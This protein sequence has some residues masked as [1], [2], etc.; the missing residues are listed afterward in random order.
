MQADTQQFVS[1]GARAEFDIYTGAGSKVPLTN[2]PG[3][4]CTSGGSGGAA[5]TLNSNDRNVYLGRGSKM[6][7]AISASH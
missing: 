7:L 3:V 5:A 2:L 4:T 1:P 6:L